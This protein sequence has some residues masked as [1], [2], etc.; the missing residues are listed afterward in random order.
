MASAESLAK[1]V[2]QMS[3]DLEGEVEDGLDSGATGITANAKEQVELNDSDVHGYLKGSIRNRD[4]V[5]TMHEA[6]RVIRA[7]AKYSP[8]IEYGT[9]TFSHTPSAVGSFDAP[10]NAP[11]GKIRQWIV[12]KG[13]IPR[14]FDSGNLIEDQ[15][16]LSYAIAHTIEELG[17]RPHP[18]MRPAYNRPSGKDR[19][20]RE[21]A[22][23][24]QD[25]ISWR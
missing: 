4:D 20:V 19:T 2:K 17:N 14:V 23:G 3:D 18:F 13:I 10:D 8:Y 5:T 9:G 22:D 16:D 1:K 7:N 21:V 24:I 12:R 11:V 6:A 15:R 25:A